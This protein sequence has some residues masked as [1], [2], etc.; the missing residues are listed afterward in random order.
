MTVFIMQQSECLAHFEFNYLAQSLLWAA[1][2]D[3]DHYGINSRVTLAD[4]LF[5]LLNN[6]KR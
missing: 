3:S 6:A 1:S 5:P 2:R 4:Q